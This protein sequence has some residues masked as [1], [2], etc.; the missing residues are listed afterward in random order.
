MKILYLVVKNNQF[1]DQFQ[2]AAALVQAMRAAPSRENIA[3]RPLTN[4]GRGWREHP[5]GIPANKGK[6]KKPDP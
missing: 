2:A 6:E 4:L 1:Q 3:A 5:G